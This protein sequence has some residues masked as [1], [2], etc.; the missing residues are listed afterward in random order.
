MRMLIGLVWQWLRRLLRYL[1]WGGLIVPLAAAGLFWFGV[2]LWT[3]VAAVAAFVVAL[4]RPAASAG[5]VPVA[6]IGTGICGLV[7]AAQ[8]AQT[9]AARRV[10]AWIVTSGAH[11]SW[12]VL[13]TGRGS[14]VKTTTMH[15]SW[16]LALPAGV[17]MVWLPSRITSRGITVLT[18]ATASPTPLGVHPGSALNGHAGVASAVATYL[19]SPAPMTRS[20]GLW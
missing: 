5:L 11:Q 4:G 12:V 14:L 16:R 1:G 20:P 15:G 7:K 10:S 18:P 17:K 13:G 8:T 9:T 2:N 19:G 6:M 3:V